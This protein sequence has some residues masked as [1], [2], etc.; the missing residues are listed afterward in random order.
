V[1]GA[2]ALAIV[3]GP[4]GSAGESNSVLLAAGDIAHCE[5]P[6]DEATAAILDNEAGTVATL[7]DNVYDSGTP[8]EFLRCYDPSWGRH[9]ART[10]PA[11]GNHEYFTAGAS[12]YFGYFGGA[13]GDRAGGYYSYDLGTWHVVVLNSVCAEVGGCH[14]GSPQERW[15]RADLTANPVSCTAAYWHHPRFSSGPH[16]SSGA[17]QALWEALY[18]H[19]ADVVL[20]GHDHL[21]ERFAPQTPAGAR[22]ETYGI[23]QF[24]VG[25]GGRSLYAVATR[26][27]NSEVVRT[28]S[29][30][31]L[32][33]TLSDTGYE[34]RFV[35]EQGKSWTDSGS[36]ACH[37]APSSTPPPP[38]PP[39][40]VDTTAPNTHIRSGPLTPTHARTARFRFTSTEPRSRFLCKLDRRAWTNC[41]S[42]RTYRRLPVGSHIFRVAARDEAGNL[43]P[44]AA[45]WRWRVVRR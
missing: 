28:D 41:S 6:G 39:L 1:G 45:I 26:A 5:S 31:V 21:Y 30:G 3:L 40:P 4:A 29:Y 9:K 24:T 17:V 12:G 16:G 15:L 8:T 36:G 37:G 18:D 22:D 7:G 19:G 11:P 25:T 44:R 14:A 38:A 13:A 20:N 2:A 43:D 10:R 33:L 27:P 42:P 34:W 23:R 35:P 32:R